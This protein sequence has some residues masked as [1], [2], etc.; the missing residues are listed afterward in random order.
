MLVNNQVHHHVVTQVAPHLDAVSVNLVVLRVPETV[1]PT[2]PSAKLNVMH[3]LKAARV[4]PDH[5]KL[6]V[7]P[8]TEAA[9][10]NQQAV[11]PNAP[12]VQADANLSAPPDPATVK[13]KK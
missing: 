5:V 4:N 11:N 12:Q 3:P 9:P 10:L 2:Q 7:V 1:Q 6:N 13:Q 8:L